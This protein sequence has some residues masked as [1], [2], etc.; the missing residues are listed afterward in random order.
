MVLSTLRLP[1]AKNAGDVPGSVEHAEH[2]DSVIPGTIEDHVVVLADGEAMNAR[3]QIGASLPCQGMAGKQFDLLVN[4]FEHTVGG[5]KALHPLRDIITNGNQ[6]GTSSWGTVYGL[7]R[8]L[9]GLGSSPQPQ[10]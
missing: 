5:S 3:L 2:F 7:R 6:I 10:P 8:H 9:G 1:R 4:G